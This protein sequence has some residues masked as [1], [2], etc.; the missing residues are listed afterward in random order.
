[1][2][3]NFGDFT[4]SFSASNSTKALSVLF[5][6][7]FVL[8]LLCYG[9]LRDLQFTLSKRCVGNYLDVASGRCGARGAG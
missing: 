3:D 2:V 9:R 4:I 6:F 1:M 8:F 5:F 7:F